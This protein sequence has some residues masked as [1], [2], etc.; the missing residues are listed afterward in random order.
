MLA[1]APPATP[2]AT[3]AATP[4]ATVVATPSATPYCNG[5][6]QGS[7]NKL[8]C[9]P[10]TPAA[11]VVATPS[12]TPY[13]NGTLQD[14]G[15]KLQCIPATPA[16]TA[17]ATPATTIKATPAAT[18]AATVKATPAATTGQPNYVIVQVELCTRHMVHQGLCWLASLPSKFLCACD[19][20]FDNIFC[21]AA[22]QTC[23]TSL[24]Q[25]A[26][27]GG[28]S[29]CPSASMCADMQW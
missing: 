16:A 9:I 15:N 10:A 18:P 2:A 1:A 8:Q 26:Q 13:C 6:L 22:T 14:S 4:A 3:S 12:A 25:Y 20:R 21:A 23:S 7:G 28:Q 19:V 27:C 5:T 29:N 17:A 11:T 24:G